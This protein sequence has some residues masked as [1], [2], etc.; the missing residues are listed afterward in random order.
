M[1]ILRL[2]DTLKKVEAER[3][4]IE[5]LNALT[6]DSWASD[7]RWGLY[8]R[9]LGLESCKERIALAADK[10]V[11][12]GG[13]RLTAMNLVS[14]GYMYRLAEVPVQEQ[15]FLSLAEQKSLQ[16]AEGMSSPF[17]E[18]Q[19]T[20]DAL[21]LQAKY[22]ECWLQYERAKSVY[23]GHID[24][25]SIHFVALLARSALDDNPK[26][27]NES[28]ET[29]HSWCS[30]P[31]RNIPHYTEPYSMTTLHWLEEACKLHSRQTGNLHPYLIEV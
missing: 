21:F 9:Y 11:Q 19:D 29:W 24:K 12:T 3:A 5:R 17:I 27:S 16:Q 13:D 1:I 30:P 6:P 7:Y 28:I 22:E 14:T 10:R 4:S 31:K 15:K 20:V 8:E 26:L 23:R 25:L 18:L 2:P